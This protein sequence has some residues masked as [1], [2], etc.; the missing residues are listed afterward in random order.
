M[1]IE[2]FSEEQQE[3]LDL[4]HCICKQVCYYFGISGEPAAVY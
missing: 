1:L 4:V 2:T 3:Q